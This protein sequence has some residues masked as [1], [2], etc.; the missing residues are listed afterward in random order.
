MKKIILN[1]PHAVPCQDFSSWSNPKNI[2]QEHDKWTDWFTDIIFAPHINHVEPVCAKLSR[3]DL[4]L[5]RLI[6]DDM[7]KIGQGIIYTK[8]KNGLSCRKI[9]IT[10]QIQR[11]HLYVEHHAKLAEKT[12]DEDTLLIDCH[13]CPNDFTE[14]G[15]AFG[16]PVDVCLGFNEGE[17]RP[18]NEIINLVQSTF[19]AHNYSVGIN[20]P[21]S[22]SI[23]AHPQ[24]PSLMIELNKRIYM[25]ESTLELTDEAVKVNQILN[26]IYFK[27]LKFQAAPLNSS[28]RFLY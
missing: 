15:N 22:N 1:I 20:T 3:Y 7:E 21:Y 14:A 10:E 16:E 24:C 19:L 27:I 18:C 28:K 26:E 13:S 11:T 5:E 2:K 4:D 9:S 12:Q 23:I 25:D 6:G 8:S 17:T